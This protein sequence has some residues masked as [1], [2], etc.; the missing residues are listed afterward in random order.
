MPTAARRAAARRASASSAAS[1]TSGRSGST[2]AAFV[3][4]D[5]PDTGTFDGARPMAGCECVR[6][7][8]VEHDRLAECDVD[9]LERRLRAEERAAV[10]LDDRTPCSA[11]AAAAG[12][13]AR[14]DE[15]LV[16]RRRAQ[17]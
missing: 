3:P 2:N 5:E 7:A 15:L 1:I 12:L 10:Q 9:L 13:A 14:A 11:V 4:N 16:R 8:H 6:V 17:G